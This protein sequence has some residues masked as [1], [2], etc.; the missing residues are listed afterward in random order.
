MTK[1]SKTRQ[2]W[3]KP[4]LTRLDTKLATM[5]GSTRNGEGGRLMKS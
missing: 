1:K 4:R 2:P 3:Q 5:G